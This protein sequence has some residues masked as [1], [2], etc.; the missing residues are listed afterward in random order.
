MDSER[1][2]RA[3]P[4]CGES[5]PWLKKITDLQTRVEPSRLKNSAK[6]ISSANAY[7]RAKRPGNGIG[8]QINTQ[9]PRIDAGAIESKFGSSAVAASVGLRTGAALIG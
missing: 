3:A 8:G 4:V 6:H 2:L 7:R 9:V 5:K 1:Q